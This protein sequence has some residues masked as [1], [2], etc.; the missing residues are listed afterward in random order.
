M[1]SLLTVF[2]D[3]TLLASPQFGTSPFCVWS[4]QSGVVSSADY[5]RASSLVVL[6]GVIFVSGRNR[7][8]RSGRLI[9][10]SGLQALAPGRTI[11]KRNWISH[12][13]IH[14]QT[15]N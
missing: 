6:P 15:R 14:R 3:R 7:T 1:T 8:R 12:M 9:L 11:A 5:Q 13:P 4:F 2:G 10:I